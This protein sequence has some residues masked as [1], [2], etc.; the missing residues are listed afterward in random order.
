MFKDFKRTMMC[1]QMRKEDIG[2]EITLNGWV[3]KERNLGP[4]IFIDL[5]DTTGISQVVFRKENDEDV[6]KE[7][8]KLRSEFVVAVRG[9]VEERE[10]KN[11]NIETGD[12]E[13]NVKSIEILDE[14][15]T[16]PIYIKDDDNA[17]EQMRLKYRYLDLRKKSFKTILN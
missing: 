17:S 9:I 6:F 2:K 4:I 3:Q 13:L 16:P 14:A 12:V 15:N 1:G 5:R 11:P 7:A 8:E 10:S